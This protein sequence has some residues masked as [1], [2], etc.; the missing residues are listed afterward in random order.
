MK[1]SGI[2][3]AG[4]LKWL[5]WV[6]PWWIAWAD[7]V[8]ITGKVPVESSEAARLAR[9]W[10]S[11]LRRGDVTPLVSR[12]DF[13]VLTERAIAGVPSDAASKQAFVERFA[14]GAA[15]SFQQGLRAFASFRFLGVV[16]TNAA[17]GVVF[18]CLSPEG[19]VNYHRYI[20]EQRA[21]GQVRI[22]DVYSMAA[23]DW[24][25]ETIRREFLAS[26]GVGNPGLA[27]RLTGPDA[28]WVRHAAMVA[29]AGRLVQQR[30]LAEFLNLYRQMP[31]ALQEDRDL[32]LM[33]LV[34]GFSADP[35]DQ[36]QAMKLW[37]RLYPTHPGADLVSFDKLAQR[38]DHAR[39]AE[40]LERMEVFVGGDPHLRALRGLQ[41][42]LAGE[43]VKGRQLAE[44]ALLAELDLVA[45]FD[46]LLGIG[47]AGKEFGYVARDLD[48]A[49]DFVPVDVRDL[50]VQQS[51]YQEFRESPEGKRWLAKPPIGR[52]PSTPAAKP[53][54]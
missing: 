54:P 16:Q 51:R 17:G 45:G 53:K 40:A 50:V 52:R 32:L 42:G 15:A 4:R 3:C 10:E 20:L 35:A 39:S 37:E 38:R 27:A 18:R 26:E 8:P 36:G 34:A 33:R 46:A 12:V 30:Q 5:A 1:P 28:E 43:R 19:G 24:F 44:E 22:P 14:P 49:V 13:T 41:V 6:L 11:Q 23:G 48:R 29:Q 7:T 31:P 2:G 21:E 25:S 9:E 47:L